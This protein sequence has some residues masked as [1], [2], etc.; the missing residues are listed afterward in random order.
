VAAVDELRVVLEE[1][2]HADYAAEADS[3]T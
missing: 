3:V 1:D 2:A